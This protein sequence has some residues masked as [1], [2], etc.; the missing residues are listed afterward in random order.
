MNAKE[1]CLVTNINIISYFFINLG[2][3]S[4]YPAIQGV[5]LWLKSRKVSQPQGAAAIKEYLDA[6]D[7]S[8]Y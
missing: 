7:H 3:P 1:D 6:V 4:S 2:Q 5:G 8:V